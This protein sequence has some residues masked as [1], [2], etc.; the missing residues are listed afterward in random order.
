MLI[1]V[2]EILILDHTFNFRGEN[3]MAVPEIG[4]GRNLEYPRVER[5]GKSVKRNLDVTLPRYFEEYTE[6][7][8]GSVL[9]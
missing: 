1:E 8:S 5:T 4:R 3:K 9:P 2:S 7:L 6:F